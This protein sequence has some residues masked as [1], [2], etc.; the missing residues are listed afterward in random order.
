MLIQLVLQHL[1]KSILDNYAERSS[2]HVFASEHH[3]IV[4]GAFVAAAVVVL[5][6]LLLLKS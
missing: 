6:Q 1:V 5:L 4:E 3:L 2:I